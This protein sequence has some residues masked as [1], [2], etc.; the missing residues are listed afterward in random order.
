[1]NYLFSFMKFVNWC[2][3]MITGTGQIV[4]EYTERTSPSTLSH[5]IIALMKQT[6]EPPFKLIA[7]GYIALQDVDRAE[8]RGGRTSVGSFTT[9]DEAIAAA[10]GQ[11]IQ[12]DSGYVQQYKT[13]CS[14]GGLVMTDTR[15]VWNR[16]KDEMGW[17]TVGAVNQDKPLLTR[18]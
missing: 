7:E 15:M 1:V 2:L 16:R 18:D 11:G 5:D 14:L 17:Y 13:Y 10:R 8:G 4:K 3:I 9:L 6:F 12:G